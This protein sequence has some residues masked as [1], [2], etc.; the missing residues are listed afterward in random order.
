MGSVNKAIILGRLGQDPVTRS[1]EGKTIC[2]FSVATDESYTNKKGEKIKNTQWH[3]VVSFGKLA[4]IAIK[5]L[6]KGDQI[7]IEGKLKTRTWEDKDGS[8]H[9]ATDIIASSFVFL[10]E[11]K[12]TNQNK[13]YEPDSNIIPFLDNDVPF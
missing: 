12:E 2:A 4:E 5:Y 13:N 1:N 3:S 6:H 9:T 11:K 10:G 7:F 8:K